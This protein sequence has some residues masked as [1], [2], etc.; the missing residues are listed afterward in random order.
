MAAAEPDHEAR[1]TATASNL[2]SKRF[3]YI[4]AS[5]S[6]GLIVID[7]ISAP[8]RPTDSVGASRVKRPASFH[9]E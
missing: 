8:L 4:Y 2:D 3:S 1:I 5:S 7:W 9:I 6:T